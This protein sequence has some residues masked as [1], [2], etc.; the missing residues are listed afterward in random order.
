M[1]RTGI[2]AKILFPM[3]LEIDS[4]RASFFFDSFSSVPFSYIQFCYIA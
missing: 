3:P 4:L 2:D 1:N